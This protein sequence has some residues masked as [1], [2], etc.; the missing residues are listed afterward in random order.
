MPRRSLIL[1][2]SLIV[3]FGTSS[4]RAS[5]APTHPNVLIFLADDMGFSDAGC[6]GGEIHTPNLDRLAAEGIRFTDFH[7]TARCWPSRAAL[8]TGY[9]AQQVRRDEIPG[10]YFPTGVGGRRPG[11]A[12]LLPAMLKPLGYRS[13]HS[14]KWHIDGPQLAAGFDRSYCLEDYDRNFYPQY[15][16]EDDVPL[17]PVNPTAG[18]YST[19][20]I[21]DYAIKYL[22]EHAERHRDQP[23]F[24]YVAFTSPHFPL[25]APAEDVAIYKGRYDIGWDAIRLERWKR[26][27]DLGIVEC[28]LS[29][30]DAKTIPAW[31]LPEAELQKQIGPGE[32]GYAVVWDLLTPGQKAF[33]SA[34]MSIHAAMVDRMDREIGR[35]L[36]QVAAMGAMENTL[37]LFMSDNGASAEQIIRG[38]GEDPAAAPGSAGTFLCLGPG[39]STACNTPLRLHKSWVHEGGI[40]TPLIVHWPAGIAAHGELRRNPSHLIDIAPTILELAGGTWPTTRN[41]AAV[42]PPPGNSLVPVFTMDNTVSHNYFWWFHNNHRALRVGDWKVVSLGLDAPWELYNLKTDRSEMTDLARTNPQKLAELCAL[43]Q[44]KMDEFRD[45]AGLDLPES[46]KKPPATK[47]AATKKSEPD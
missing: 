47:P 21:A 5:N 10:V 22:K 14:G 8:M 2:L 46:A 32:V 13:Y 15:T 19:T 33:Q 24:A 7:N 26:M 45:Q 1:C 31:N 38:D 43:W 16:F 28:A 17:P 11:W 12:K 20:A 41:R 35:V 30:R 25:Q 29:E 42:P 44:K 40:S 39:W 4:S 34:K 6:Y 23:F 27:R 36:Q 37:V 3:W 18:Y 9:Y